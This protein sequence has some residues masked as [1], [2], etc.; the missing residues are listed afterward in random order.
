MG[1]AQADSVCLI[2]KPRGAQ[3]PPHP[4]APRSPLLGR[5]SPRK[6][7][8]RNADDDLSLHACSPLECV[9]RLLERAYRADDDAER[10]PFS[11]FHRRSNAARAPVAADVESS[12][13]VFNGTLPATVTRVAPAKKTTPLVTSIHQRG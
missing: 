13:A 7:I 9:R 4:W 3:P 6:V 12:N 5:G 8:I 11:T 1:A 10:T 2:T